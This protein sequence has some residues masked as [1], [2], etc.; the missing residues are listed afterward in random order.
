MSNFCSGHLTV[1]QFLH[2]VAAIP[3]QISDKN[4]L[5]VDIIVTTLQ[6]GELIPHSILDPGDNVSI[7]VRQH[8]FQC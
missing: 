8:H 2:L 4:E 7:A 1:S 3:L 6:T 5:I